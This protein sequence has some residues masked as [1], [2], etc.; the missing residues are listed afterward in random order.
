M[1]A[2]PDT[3]FL[4]ALYVPQSTSVAAIA[5]Y[6]RMTEPL[7][8]SAL[9]LGEF[10]QSVRFQIFRH[11]RDPTQGY[12]RKT[13]LEAL[14]KLQAN[15]DSGALAVAPA[16]WSDVLALAEQ[17]SSRHTPTGGHRYLDILHVA[18]ALHLGAS[19]FLSFDAN[20]RKLAAAAGLAARP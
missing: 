7:Y 11:G 4:C 14:A 20:Q 1:K 9:L 5:H 10:R 19:E 15:L 6:Q 17:I 16:E 12:A 18:T 2:Y 3:S 13:G 8:V